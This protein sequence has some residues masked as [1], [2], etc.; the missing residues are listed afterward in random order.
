MKHNSKRPTKPPVEQA[1]FLRLLAERLRT[2]RN[3]R[4]MSRKVLAHQ[5]DISERYL[6]QLEAGEANYSI[7]LLRR[8]AKAMGVHLIDLVDDRP[9][10][11][12]ETVLLEQ[13]V[14]RLSPSQ[15]SE[16][17]DL[18][19]RHFEGKTRRRWKIHD[20]ATARGP[21]ERA[22]SRTRSHGRAAEWNESHRDF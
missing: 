4:G 15:L 8:I 20:W 7:V 2:M 17:R 6:A 21:A 9:E 10:R 1:E 13:F 14:G 18:L 16:A 19:L 3:R 22:V 5:S 11:Q 12:L